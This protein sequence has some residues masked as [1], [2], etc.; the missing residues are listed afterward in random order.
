MKTWM[1]DAVHVEIQIVELDAVRVRL[2]SI[3]GHPNSVNDRRRIFQH[4]DYWQW[5][6]LDQPPVKRRNSHFVIIEL[7]SKLAA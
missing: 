6:P 2:R 5:V 1:Y 7:N 4:V 3:S